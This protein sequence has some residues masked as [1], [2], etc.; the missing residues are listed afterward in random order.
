MNTMN[1]KGFSFV[2]LVV[3][4]V[5]VSVVIVIW[6]FT[7]GND[8]KRSMLTEGKMFIE[9]VIAQ[10]RLYLAEKSEFWVSVGTVTV[11][12][13]LN[14]STLQNK[15]F[16]VFKVSSSTAADIL[17]IEVYSTESHTN[18]VMIRGVWNSTIS[19]DNK[20]DFYKFYNYVS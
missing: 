19:S 8:V 17:T 20:V 12:D 16:K 9:Q 11:A 18:K 13:A 4:I 1:N 6:G 5:I 2:E 10:E 15:Y 14:I 3:V 7:G